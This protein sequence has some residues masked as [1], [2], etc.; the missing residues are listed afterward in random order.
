VPLSL[1]FLFSLLRCRCYDQVFLTWNEGKE[2]EEEEEDLI[3]VIN[4]TCDQPPFTCVQFTSTIG[5]TITYMDV[6]ISHLD[7]CLHSNVF[8]PSPF[9]PYTLP[10]LMD[11]SSSIHSTMIRAALLRAIR[12]CSRRDDFKIEEK[13]I[14]LSLMINQF[15]VS[16]IDDCFQSFSQEF[17]LK[18][19]SYRYP[20]H[21]YN[22]LRRRIRDYDELCQQG[23]KNDHTS[24]HVTSLPQKKVKTHW[25]KNLKR[26]WE[27]ESNKMSR[28]KQMKRM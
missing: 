25:K 15:P 11:H 21:A 24:I 23:Q 26:H 8:H 19:T 27:N 9:E 28:C 13:H 17:N 2:E 16:L 20:Q 3:N 12:C 4:Q 14:Q 22:D 1:C 5:T 6:T 18:K 10:Y 7:G